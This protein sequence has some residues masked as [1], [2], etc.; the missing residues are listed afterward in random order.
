MG[1]MGTWEKESKVFIHYL[2]S[3][4]AVHSFLGA[5]SLPLVDQ[6]FIW[7][8]VN[9]RLVLIAQVVRKQFSSN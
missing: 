1:R 3:G 7:A 5:G 2:L 4:L 8:H 6:P 9:P